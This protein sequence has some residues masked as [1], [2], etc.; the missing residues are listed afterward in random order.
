MPPSLPGE[1]WRPIPSAP[2]YFASSFGRISGPKRAIMSPRFSDSGYLRISIWAAGRAKATSVHRLVC[3]A[4]HGAPP[5][6]GH[7]A[8]HKDNKRTNNIPDNLKWATPKENQADRIDHGTDLSG[9]DH[10]M[11]KLSAKQAREIREQ[12][13][14]HRGR[15]RVPVGFRQELARRYG[16]APHTIAAIGR[17]RSR[18]SEVANNG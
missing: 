8:A 10:P 3:E 4:F 15:S 14:R 7:H 12:Y 13:E 18:K 17:N 11:A 16:V 5:T 9:E 1:E 6:P 2:R